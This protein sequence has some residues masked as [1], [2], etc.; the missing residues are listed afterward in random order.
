MIWLQAGTCFLL[1]VAYGFW[2]RRSS[3]QMRRAMHGKSRRA[4][5][6]LGSAGLIAGLALLAGGLYGVYA[7]GGIQ[8]GELTPWG[9]I[10][11]AVVG[12]V[13]IHMQVLGA[14]A[15]I[16]LVLDEETARRNKTSISKETKKT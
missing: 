15:M 3:E 14:A 5:T 10:A 6:M 8:G 13:F 9:W 16:T 7:L 1:W 4:R 2:M 12:T 11:V